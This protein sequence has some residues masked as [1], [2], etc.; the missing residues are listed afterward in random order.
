MNNRV[1]HDDRP[2]G[3]FDSGIGGLTV[4]KAVHRLLPYENIIYFG[5]LAR[6]PYGTKSKEAITEYSLQSVN[7]LIKQ[8]VKMI[9]IACNT[10][11][12]TAGEEIDAIC[13]KYNIVLVNLIDC[14]V[15]KLW[16]LSE[17]KIDIN[18][19]ILKK[20]QCYNYLILA[21]PATIKSNYYQRLLQVIPLTGAIYGQA[22]E[23]FV[24]II[25]DGSLLYDEL[26]NIN[27][28]G[29]H[30][31]K[32]IVVHYLEKFFPINIST[33]IL[34][35]T[36]YPIITNV[37]VAVLK[38]YMINNQCSA[39]SELEYPEIIDPA[40]VVAHRVKFL[41]QG[42]VNSTYLCLQQNSSDSQGAVKFYIT[43]AKERFIKIASIILE[44]SRQTISDHVAVI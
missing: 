39:D 13:N 14:V 33:I 17:S 28:K 22:C 18:Q 25:E 37:I 26:G 10:I 19:E 36:H 32:E 24:P 11:A 41:L 43:D 12:S 6:I 30:I 38:E 7:F 42:L 20:D 8:N 15:Q 29:Q 21:T 3:I 31:V 27:S 5:D 23:L 40:I 9:V 35:C 34:G 4:V 44:Q 2:I 1:D 16:D